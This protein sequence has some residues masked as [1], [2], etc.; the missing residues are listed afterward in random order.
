MLIDDTYFVGDISITSGEYSTLTADIARYEKEIIN[1]VFGYELGKLILAYNDS[2]EQR[3][4]DLVEGVEYTVEYNNRDQLVR[5]N[6]LINDDKISII[7]YYVYYRYLRD[8]ATFNMPTGEMKPKNENSSN[9]D[10]SLKIMNISNRLEEMIGYFGQTLVEP[11]LYN[12]FISNDYET[13][14]PEL[15]LRGINIG[16]SHDL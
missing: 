16:N 11:S 13:N 4:I 14:Y 9:A 1:A 2:S 3:I 7:A 8:K 15:I 5:W 10:L 12:Y 6:G